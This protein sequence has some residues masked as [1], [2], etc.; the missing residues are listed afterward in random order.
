MKKKEFNSK[1]DFIKNNTNSD[2]RIY[3]ITIKAIVPSISNI[4]TSFIKNYPYK[5]FKYNCYLLY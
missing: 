3:E 1:K 4:I 2:I 5:Y